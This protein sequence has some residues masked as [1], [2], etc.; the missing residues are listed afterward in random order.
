[1]NG[2]KKLLIVSFLIVVSVTGAGAP[3]KLTLML[4]WF[5]NVDHLPIYLARETGMFAEKGL[6]VKILSPSDTADAL[7]LA[8][9]GHADIAEPP[10]LPA[11]ATT[12]TS[13]SRAYA[14]ASRTT[15]GAAPCPAA[16]TTT[17]SAPA[18]MSSSTADRYRGSPPA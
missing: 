18:S 6:T 14:T 7:K 9:S 16:A 3:E 5:P 15:F 1:M 13:F 10:W 12:T 17:T 11:D 4:D 8:A 2:L